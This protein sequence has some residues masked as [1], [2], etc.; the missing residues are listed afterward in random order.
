MNAAYLEFP[1]EYCP[2][3]SSPCWIPQVDWFLRDQSFPQC[4]TFDASVAPRG[5]GTTALSFSQF[6]RSN[7]KKRSKEIVSTA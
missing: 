7:L 5:L 1:K 2:N 4:D 6:P 3:V